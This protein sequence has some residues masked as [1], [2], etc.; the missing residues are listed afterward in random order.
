MP[1]RREIIRWLLL[2]LLLLLFYRKAIKPGKKQASQPAIVR[3]SAKTKQS[4]F[5]S[6]MIM[7]SR[8]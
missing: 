3:E 2:L 8:K 6:R 1:D 4:T 7:P 5:L